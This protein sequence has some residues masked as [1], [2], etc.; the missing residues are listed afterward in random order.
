MRGLV[1]ATCRM[2]ASMD[3]ILA[4]LSAF[5]LPFIGRQRTMTFTH[6]LMVVEEGGGGVKPSA[7]EG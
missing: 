2:F 7:A 3:R 5:S 1:M 4:Q 6:S